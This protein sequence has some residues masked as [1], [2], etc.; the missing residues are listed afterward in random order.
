MD[1]VFSQS[2][3][4]REIIESHGW[5]LYAVPM[6]RGFSLDEMD[7]MGAAEQYAI[8]QDYLFAPIPTE[9]QKLSDAY[10]ITKGVGPAL[11]IPDPTDKW[12]I[13]IEVT[14]KGSRYMAL[15]TRLFFHEKCAYVT[16]PRNVHPD[17]DFVAIG[18][19]TLIDVFR[20]YFRII[21]PTEIGLAEPVASPDWN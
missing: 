9:G 19:D 14:K 4:L 13:S 16:T 1:E 5:S 8:G 12:W 11:D 17:P 3:E 20:K 7:G 2:K 18:Y 21:E 15:F 6:G 10:L